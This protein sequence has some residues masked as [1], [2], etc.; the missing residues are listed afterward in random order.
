MSD[1]GIVAI[2]KNPGEITLKG[3]TFMKDKLPDDFEVCL[4][5][6]NSGH[7]SAACWCPGLWSTESREVSG[8]V[9]VEPYRRSMFWRGCQ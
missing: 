6:E 5:V 4:I 8:K 2:S 9:E 3:F 7:L 1:K